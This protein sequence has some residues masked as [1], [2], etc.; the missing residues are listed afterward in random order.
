MSMP[1]ASIA[2]R[3]HLVGAQHSDM[4]MPAT[5]IALRTHFGTS[6][7]GN[8]HHD[9]SVDKSGKVSRKKII[10]QSIVLVF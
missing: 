6:P 2:S 10:E 7:F 1:A 3:G 8:C 5:S 4:S 9:L